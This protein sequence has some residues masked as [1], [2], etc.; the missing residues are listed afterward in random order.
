MD[1]PSLYIKVRGV[2]DDISEETVTGVMGTYGN[3][4][5][6]V[7]GTAPMARGFEP[8]DPSWVWDGVWHVALKVDDDVTVPSYIVCD[9]DSWQLKRAWKKLRNCKTPLVMSLTHRMSKIW[10]NA[11]QKG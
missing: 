4:T 5:S 1:N 10:M 9:G 6:C 11:K 2:A 8:G 3:V 7:R